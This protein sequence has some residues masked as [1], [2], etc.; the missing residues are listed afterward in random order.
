MHRFV[1]G[2][3]VALSLVFG[4][5]SD[6]GD[7]SDQAVGDGEGG[8]EASGAQFNE[9][10]VTFVRGMIPHHE[11]AVVMS[12][13]AEENADSD[14]VR[15]LADEIEAAQEPEIE[16][17]TAFLEEWG[18]SASEGGMDHDEM[19]GM[20]TDEQMGELEE[21]MGAEFDRLFLEMMV[22]HHEGAVEMAQVEVEDGENEEAQELAGE[23]IEAQEAEIAE[24][25]DLLA[26]GT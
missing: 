20:M 24:M 26:E 17:M 22:M 21:A 10:D 25:E 7:S 23:I 9:A 18:E 15:E 6:G 3:V 4:A 16:Q 5:C 11:Q 12:E 2:I 19:S 13:L 14:A 1:G 8:E